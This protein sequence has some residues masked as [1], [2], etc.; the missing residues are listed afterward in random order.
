MS[1]LSSYTAGNTFPAPAG[2][3]YRYMRLGA[4][5]NGCPANLGAYYILWIQGMQTQTGGAK[6]ETNGCDGQTVFTS[7]YTNNSTN[8]MYWG[9]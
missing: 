2:G 3:M 4:G 6:L 9:F 7:V 1:S 5:T 8:Y